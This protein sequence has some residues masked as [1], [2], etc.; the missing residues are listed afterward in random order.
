MII[1]TGY[2]RACAARFIPY[3]IAVLV[4]TILARFFSYYHLGLAEDI[5]STILLSRGIVSDVACSIVFASGLALLPPNKLL[6]F[7]CIFL[8]ALSYAS[9][10]ANLSIN[11]SNL[12]I[13]DSRFLSEEQFLAK[14]LVSPFILGLLAIFLIGY[15]ASLF[16]ISKLQPTLRPQWMLLITFP[17]A[18]PFI[19]L[20]VQQPFWQQYNVFE[21]NISALF[22]AIEERPYKNFLETDREYARLT[23]L[24]LSET[25]IVPGITGKYKKPNILIV[26]IEGLSEQFVQNGSMPNLKKM[27]EDNIHFSNFIYHQRFTEN[28]LYS[29]MCGD[30]PTMYRRVLIMATTKKA[31]PTSVILGNKDSPNK[32]IAVAHGK[33]NNCLPKVLRAQGYQTAFFQA[34]NVTFSKKN[35]FM[36]NAGISLLYGDKKLRNKYPRTEADAAY[37][38]LSFGMPDGVFYPRVKK[39]L[40]N[41]QK[42]STPWFATLMTTSTHFPL[43]IKDEFKGKFNNGTME[44]FYTADAALAEFIASL[45]AEGLLNNTLL[46]ITG[47]ESGASVKKGDLSSMLAANWGTLVIKTPDNIKYS[48][49]DYFVHSDL[50]TSILDYVGQTESA[51]RGRSVFRKYEGFR[52]VMFAN[53][54]TDRWFTWHEPDKMIFCA[55]YFK[56]CSNFKLEGDLFNASLSEERK[57]K[58][59]IDLFVSVARKSDYLYSGKARRSKPNPTQNIRN[60]TVGKNVQEHDSYNFFTPDI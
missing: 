35:L 60:P 50:M 40:Q 31:I 19:A 29:I 49:R 51:V 39:E 37:K 4:V 6:N 41:L 9:N 26:A 44:A 14:S 48:S 1:N 15:Y 36:R 47:D 11:F 43:F 7:A 25:E 22:K 33:K 38:G 23:G 13:A 52:P 24:K 12:H 2:L 34:S 3:F 46:I 8:F 32:W 10:I 42:S 21:E 53:I 45:D 5:L 17:V 28:G 27:A 20:K 57:D 55:N 18:L 30:M 59:L 16:V 54:R 58:K 56:I